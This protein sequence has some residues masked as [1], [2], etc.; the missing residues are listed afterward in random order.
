MIQF[1]AAE[2]RARVSLR[3]AKLLVLGAALALSGCAKTEYIGNGNKGFW[4]DSPAE[5]SP[6]E[7]FARAQPHL[8]ATWTARCE[9]VRNHDEYCDKMP[10]DHMVRKGGY[11]YLTR[12]SYPYKSYD[13]Y[14]QYA[15]RVDVKTGE[16]I[17]YE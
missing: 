12:T 5:I 1:D 4:S 9:K 7:A 8:P 14:T 2:T 3:G 17:P 11:Y 16:V 15:V 13:A 10:T 6:N